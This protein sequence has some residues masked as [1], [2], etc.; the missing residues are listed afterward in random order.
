MLRNFVLL[1]KLK[2]IG[3]FFNNNSRKK[4]LFNGSEQW[5]KK[6]DVFHVRMYA[7]DGAEVAEL[8][9]LLILYKLKDPAPEFD[10]GIYRDDG[11]G[12]SDPLPGPKRNRLRKKIIMTMKDLDLGS[13]SL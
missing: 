5:V 1:A 12:E 2:G 8:V 3:L 9:V 6:G 4:I 10:F 13:T 7:Y 11:L